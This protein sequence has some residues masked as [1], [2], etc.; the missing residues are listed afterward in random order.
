MDYNNIV[1]VGNVDVV[2]KRGR[3]NRSFYWAVNIDSSWFINHLTETK[4]DLT[5]R[6]L[7]F[8]SPKTKHSLFWATMFSMQV[9]KEVSV[10][11]LEDGGLDILRISKGAVKEI[12]F[13]SHGL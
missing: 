8:K 11:A 4:H 2:D 9:A 12:L 7:I 1:D 3:R 13:V 5:Y 6:V 10:S